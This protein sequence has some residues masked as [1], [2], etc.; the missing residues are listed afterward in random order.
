MNEVE[1]TAEPSH[2]L[3][4][5]NEY[6]RVFKVEAAP[7]AS[8]LMHRH[9]HDYLFV[10]LGDS[11][12]SNE[13]EGKTPVEL[14][15]SDGETRFVAGNFA[16]LAKNL[17]SR[18]FRNVTIELMQDEKMKEST[19][20]WTETSGERS[21][22]GGHT[23]IL[24][25]KDGARITETNLDPGATVP[26][27]HHQGPH[28]VVAVTDLDLRSDAEG[29]APAPVK[30]GAGDIRWLAGGITHSVTNVSARPARLILVEF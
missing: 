26:S 15:L 27:H 7:G 18:P 30:I 23:K 9:R 24:F 2:H 20:N 19:G 12:I 17:S 16:H 25:V 29:S 11:D 1:I 22:P 14:K 10:T 21:F 13:V 5:E 4:L 6:V 28:L 3:A 8:T